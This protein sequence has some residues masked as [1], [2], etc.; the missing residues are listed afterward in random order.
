MQETRERLALAEHY[1]AIESPDKALEA[2]AS[3]EGEAAQLSDFHLLRARSLRRLERPDEA[4]RAIVA[5][6]EIDPEDTALLALAS[7]SCQDRNDLSG[8][9][10]MIL[11]AL[12]V[13]PEEPFLLCQ[14]ARLVG[15]ALQFDKAE[16]LI[17]RAAEIDSESPAILPSRYTLA[18]FQGRNREAAKIAR[19]LV[20]QDPDN[21]NALLASG[22]TLAELGHLS[23]ARKQTGNAVALSP[24]TAEGYQE[25]L[26][27]IKV[28][29]HWS[30]AILAPINRLGP[31]AFWFGFIVLF[32]G[33]NLAGLKTAAIVVL[34]VYLSLAAYSWIGPWVVRKILQRGRA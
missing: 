32:I 9:E 5:G 16:K 11:R 12:E 26:R 17:E 28:R 34:A 31:G 1:L 10:R 23:E 33:L 24:E 3:A 2:L 30:L 22:L 19:E 20:G 6:L 29:S 4:D 21:P 25:E 15:Q 18:V 27:D 14:Y 8:A 13:D 7:E